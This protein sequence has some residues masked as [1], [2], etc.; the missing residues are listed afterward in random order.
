[1]GRTLVVADGRR[2]MFGHEMACEMAPSHTERTLQRAAAASAVAGGQHRAR[3]SGVRLP[4]S[5][6]ARRW[7]VAGHRP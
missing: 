3:T 7:S 5:S 1:M 2:P 6:S 4:M